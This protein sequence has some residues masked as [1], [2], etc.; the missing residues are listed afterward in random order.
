MHWRLTVY[1]HKG[2]YP[3]LVVHYFRLYLP[4]YY[5]TEYAIVLAHLLLPMLL[6]APQGRRPAPPLP[7]PPSRSAAGM[8]RATL[9]RGQSPQPSL[10]P[11]HSSLPPAPR[12]G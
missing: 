10:T 2:Q 9:W 5:L 8:A 7:S 11:H 12:T 4:V 6:H 3:L 1:I